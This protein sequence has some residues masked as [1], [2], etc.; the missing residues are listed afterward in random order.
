MK[1]VF[2]NGRG[3]GKDPKKRYIREMIMEYNLNFV[4][5]LETIKQN[6]TKN[7]LNNLC[8]GKN[9]EWHWNPP[10]GH[11]GWILVGKNRD[12]FD[13]MHTEHGEYFV[14]LLVYDKNAKFHWNLIAVYGDA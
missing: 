6:F 2:W 4:G 9:Y 11:S 12:H 1:G 8:N 10:R 13:I 5:V 3:I 14:R 7:E